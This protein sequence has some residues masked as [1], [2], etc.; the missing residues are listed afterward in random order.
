MNKKGFTLMELIV[1]FVIMAFIM[2]MIFPA[3]LELMNNN[4]DEMYKSY[5]TMMV[6]YAKIHP[7]RKTSTRIM[8]EDLDELQKVKDE[9][10]GYVDISKT[11]DA[12]GKE[13]YSYKPYIKCTEKYR[14]CYCSIN[15]PIE[16]CPAAKK[17]CGANSLLN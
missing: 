4:N 17:D 16:S 12:S 13:V 8:L 1:A 9:C 7:N 6:E 2:M 5:E 15:R 3:V 10:K 14:T 11:I